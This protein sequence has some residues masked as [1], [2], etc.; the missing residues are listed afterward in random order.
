MVALTF[1]DG[2]RREYP[3]GTTGLDVAKGISPS[4]AKRTVTMAL[5]GTLADLADPIDHDAKIEFI[6]RE[7]PRAL[8]LI[9]HDAA[10]VLAEAVQS[11]WPGTQVTIGPVIENGFYYDFARNQPFTLEDL[12]VIEKKMRD[13][14]ARDKP[15]TKE[16]W[17][18]EK[19]KKTFR[20]MGEAFKVEL[21]DAI[22]ADQQ[23]KIYQQGDWFDLCRG[24]HMTSVGK[25]GSA[26]KLMKVAGAYW[27]GDS[28]NPMLT[29]IYGTAFAKQEELDAYLKQLEEAEKRDHRRLGRE[30]DLFHFQEEGPGVVFWHPKG[31]TLFQALERY[32]RR[33]QG[34]AGYVEV[35]SPQLMDAS[36]WVASGHMEKYRQLMFLTEHRNDDER[37]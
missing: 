26:F 34:Q 23:I 20:D 22:P 10:H 15:F 12:P 11:L 32:I 25:V 17:S 31:W 28:A 21:I 7:D 2:A 4:L 27:R 18:R 13:I 5:D 37:I 33:R 1:P 35:N 3:T 24:P 19:A 30:L 6:S 9:R 14:V 29:R 8:E 16:V 36:L